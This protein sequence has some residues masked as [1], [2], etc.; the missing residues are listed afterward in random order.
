MGPAAEWDE[1]PQLAGKDALHATNVERPLVWS[2]SL[3]DARDLHPRPPP[4]ISRPIAHRRR[5][6]ADSEGTDRVTAPPTL[7]AGRYVN[8]GVDRQ[9]IR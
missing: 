5:C 1:P 3:L 4:G 8:I 7:I 6:V 2:T 9:T